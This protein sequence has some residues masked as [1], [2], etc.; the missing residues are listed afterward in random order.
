[1]IR[2]LAALLL[3]AL[4][5]IA[6]ARS[7]PPGAGAGLPWKVERVVDGDTVA[8]GGYRIRLYGLNAPEIRGVC[9]E[10]KA[11]GRRAKARLEALIAGAGVVE[12]RPAPPGKYSQIQAWLLLDGR[13]AAAQLI[14]EGL[15][16]P[17]HGGAKRGWC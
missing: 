4:A 8:A 11:L 1:M 6:P 16:R 5:A 14:A 3:A 10:E 9:D 15:A 7:C 17:Y 13:D 2:T 12:L